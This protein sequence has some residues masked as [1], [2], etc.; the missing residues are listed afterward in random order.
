MG[1]TGLCRSS[2]QREQQA[3]ALQHRIALTQQAGP[4]TMTLDGRRFQLRVD[5]SGPGFQGDTQA[6]LHLHVRADEQV[7]G[8]GVGRTVGNEPVA[9]H[10]GTFRLEGSE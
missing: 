8:R 3:V 7:P 1:R 4:V 10:G 9:S 6:I 2:K 5:D